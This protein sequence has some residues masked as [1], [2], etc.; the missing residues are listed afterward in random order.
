M[1]KRANEAEESQ[2]DISISANGF[3]RNAVPCRS[4]IRGSERQGH[5]S[6]DEGFGRV[7]RQGGGDAHG[8]VSAGRLIHQ[9]SA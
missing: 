9:A 2:N 8:R 7:A 5:P 6:N 1:K 4:S 3:D